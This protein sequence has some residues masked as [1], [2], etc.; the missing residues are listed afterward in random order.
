MGF[1]TRYFKAVSAAKHNKIN[2]SA[3]S[4]S[5]FEEKGIG[6]FVPSYFDTV[7]IAIYL[8]KQ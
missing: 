8:N 3:S 7:S 4:Y 1:H 2:H 6:D 5:C